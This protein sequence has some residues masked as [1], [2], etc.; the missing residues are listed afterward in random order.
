MPNY[1]AAMPS[2]FN[3]FLA[4]FGT[5]A[6]AKYIRKPA[7]H[8][9]VIAGLCGGSSF[10]IKSIAIY[11]IAGALLFFVYREQAL[12][13]NESAPPHR[14][15]LYLAFLASCL[16][17]FV[18]A[19][20]KLVFSI[21]EIPEYLHFVFPGVLIALLLLYRERTPPA[22]SDGRRFV[23]ILRMAVPFL[24]AAL[25]PISLFF[26]FYWRHGAL[27]ALINGLFVA[28]FR[29]LLVTRVAPN[30]LIFEYPSVLA[31]LLLT[32]T[33]KLRGL[34]RTVLS[35]LLAL[36]GA[37]VLLGA[38]SNDL[39]YLIGLTS[40]L[41]AIPVLVVAALLALSAKPQFRQPGLEGDQQVALLLTMTALFSM[42]QFPYSTPGYF[43]YVAPL[44]VLLAAALI[45]RFSR[46][47]HILLR[48]TIAFYLLF[49]IF[50]LRPRFMGSRHPL[51]SDDTALILPRAGGLRVSKIS[52]T[53][54]AELITF[55]KNL[56]GGKPILAAPDCP[57]IYF[58]SGAKNPTPVLYDSLEDP[59]N[60]ERDIQ[61]VLN[62]PNFLKVVVVNDAAVSAVY[63]S[64]LLHSLVVARFPSSRRI[65]SFTVY[66][67]Q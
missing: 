65:G 26:I 16:A 14:T 37:A 2:W 29:R 67:R 6:L 48:V 15:L 47:P 32:E 1:T 55:V 41:G 62:R 45:S 42:I 61:A 63:Q 25:L 51:D 43:W 27:S 18:F 58:L 60:Y 13:R 35:V 9:L 21:G 31:A 3:L 56:A 4:T 66:W 50:V 11:Y 20:T 59:R 40:A 30:G 7:I 46:P 34:P 39:A 57:E 53:G 28:P 38:L 33:A 49:P 64:Q 24:L 19:L 10:L 52:A 44:V 8:W 23:V 54:Y 5:L 12:S 17:L 36:L 22:V